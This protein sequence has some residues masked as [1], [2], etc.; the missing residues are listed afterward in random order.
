MTERTGDRFADNLPIWV[1]GAPYWLHP[2][3]IAS[4]GLTRLDDGTYQSSCDMG[5]PTQ[6]P[7]SSG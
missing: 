3:E 4:A 1:N 7:Q 2:E 5:G 6:H